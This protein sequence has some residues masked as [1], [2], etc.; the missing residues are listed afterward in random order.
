MSA[1]RAH[2]RHIECQ[3]HAVV[4]VILNSLKG[5]IAG[6]YEMTDDVCTYYKIYIYIVAHRCTVY[7]GLAQARPNKEQLL[8]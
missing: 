1:D 4:H 2:M 8:T 3:L 7:V 5:N 6:T